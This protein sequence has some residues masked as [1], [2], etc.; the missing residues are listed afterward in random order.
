MSLY[1]RLQAAGLIDCNGLVTLVGQPNGSDN[2]VLYSAQ[3]FMLCNKLKESIIDYNSICLYTAAMKCVNGG[4]PVRKPGDNNQNSPDNLIGLC[5]ISNHF[6][7]AAYKYGWP[8]YNYNTTN[9]GKWSIDSWFGRQLGLIGFMQYC[10]FGLINPLR[11]L[12]LYVGIWLTS[13]QPLSQ[14]SDRLLAHLMIETIGDKW[15]NRPFRAWWKRRLRLQYTNG[16]NSVVELYFSPS[17]VFSR[18]DW[19]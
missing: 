9:P 3:Y 18:V 4:N 1:E 15:W 16:I 7:K 10:A 5:S 14:S 6:A 11:L 8:I 2:G 12:A 19:S 17:H 13:R